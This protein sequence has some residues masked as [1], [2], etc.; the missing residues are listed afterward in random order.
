[1]N[2]FLAMACGVATQS[3]CKFKHGAVVVRHG[4]VLG[5]S[6]NVQKNDPLYV[7]WTHSQVHAEIRALQR[8][9]FPKKVTVFVARINGHGEPRNSK[10][11]ANCQT[12]LDSLQCK[13]F[14]TEDQ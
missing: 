3:E 14:Y 5:S 12:V 13:V 6:P 4:K 7:D 9:G 2:R 8:A 1:M 10:P 11:C